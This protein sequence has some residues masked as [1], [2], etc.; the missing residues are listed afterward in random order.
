GKL[1]RDVADGLVPARAA[2][3]DFG[4]EQAPLEPERLAEMRALGAEPAAIGRML[5][6][7]G[8]RDLTLAGHGCGDSAA[9]PAIGA[10]GADRIHQV[11]SRAGEGA[12]ARQGGGAQAV[13]RYGRSPDGRACPSTSL[14]LV[15]LP[16]WG[17]IVTPPPPAAPAPAA[18]PL[19]A[20]GRS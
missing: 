19:R 10:S 20:A 18:L 14:R 7:A 8:D 9:D 4:M 1:A 17:K 5:G 12:P 2:A 15:P 11:P 3:V 16:R 6:I 13:A